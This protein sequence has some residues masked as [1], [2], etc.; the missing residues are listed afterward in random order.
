MSIGMFGHAWTMTRMAP[1]D[2]I[3][4]RHVK[5]NGPSSLRPRNCRPH[6]VS[7][8]EGRQESQASEKLSIDI[9]RGD[10]GDRTMASSSHSPCD[11]VSARVSAAL[12]RQFSV[13]DGKQMRMSRN[14]QQ[15]FRNGFGRLQGFNLLKL[16]ATVAG[17]IAEFDGDW[18]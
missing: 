6:E 2:D 15:L 9:A 16:H 5:G 12:R 8:D 13:R 3:R 11:F 7:P 17:G 14:L 4:P 1:F 10:K 18:P